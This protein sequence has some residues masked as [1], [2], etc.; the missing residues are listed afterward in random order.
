M[1]TVVASFKRPQDA[2][3]HSVPRPCS[4][5]P[6]TH[7]CPADSWTLTGKSGLDPR[8]GCSC[9]KVHPCDAGS[10]AED[11]AEMAELR[12][13]RHLVTGG[14]VKP[15]DLPARRLDLTCTSTC[16]KQV[17]MVPASASRLSR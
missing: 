12:S 2:L 9:G 7:A 11:I 13:S 3:L 14:V 1:K 16:G 5:P 15:R 10:L 6:P 17:S 8:L 4:R